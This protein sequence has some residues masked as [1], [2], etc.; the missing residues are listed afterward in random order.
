MHGQDDRQFPH[1]NIRIEAERYV[2]RVSHFITICCES[3]RPVFE[4]PARA[5]WLIDMLR[6]ESDTHGFAV[7][8]YC[9]MPDHFHALVSGLDEGSD[10]MAFVRAFKGRSEYQYRLRQKIRNP[11]MEKRTRTAR[12]TM[13]ITNATRPVREWPPT[14]QAR[15]TAEA[16]PPMEKR[17]RTARATMAATNPVLWQKKFYDHILRETDNFDAVAGYIWMNPVRAGLCDD[18]R[19]YPYSGSFTVDWKKGMRPVESWV[20]DWKSRPDRPHWNAR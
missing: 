16:N 3:R 11:P 7:F 20:P 18:A 17:P 9:V 10:L 15:T 2:G 12:A 13:A 8:A 6:A 19:D 4:N 5:A 1:K 14:P